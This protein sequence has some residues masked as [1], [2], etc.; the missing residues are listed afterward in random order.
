MANFGSGN[1]Y[2][3]VTQECG[4]GRTA[5]EIARL[6]I[7]GGT[8]VIQMR[9]KNSSPKE[10]RVLALSMCA[11]CKDKGRLF[12]VNDDPFLAKEVDAHG[13]HLGQSDI[14]HYGLGCVRQML[15]RDK[16]IGVSTHSFVEALEFSKEN[17]DYIA[18]GP[19]YPTKTKDYYI[20]TGGI[21]EVLDSVSKPVFF[22]GGIT[23]SN[24]DELLALGVK[25]I[26]LIRGVLQ[27]NDITQAVRDF[28]TK[29]EG[30]SSKLK[31]F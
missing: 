9:E 31:K 28:K 24:V 5:L 29:L 18:Y 27:V 25:N 14:L 8:D 13:V 23:F 1:L 11:L 19:I 17:V 16:I 10:L 3:V 30:I 22:I 20:G 4:L 21:K 6:A 26:A 2:V 7:D 12:I 15:G